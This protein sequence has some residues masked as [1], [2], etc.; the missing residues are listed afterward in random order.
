MLTLKDEASNH[1]LQ[2]ICDKMK[3]A[4]QTKVPPD[5]ISKS[6]EK[7]VTEVKRESRL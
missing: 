6:V 4:E 1:Y 3:A 2:I 7:P 5:R